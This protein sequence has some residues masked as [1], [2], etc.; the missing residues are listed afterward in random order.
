MLHTC[1]Y[2]LELRSTTILLR[3][4]SK[5][6][7]QKRTLWFE[8][9]SCELFTHTYKSFDGALNLK[10][11]YPICIVT[12]TAQVGLIIH[13]IHIYPICIVTTT[14]HYST[15]KERRTFLPKSHAFQSQRC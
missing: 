10:V 2:I 3:C 11:V 6:H 14:K 7:L 15:I 5:F 4:Q 1:V 9:S 8:I 13:V 12:T